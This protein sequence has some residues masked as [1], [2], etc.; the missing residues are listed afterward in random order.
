MKTILIAVLAGLAVALAGVLGY[1]KLTQSEL[2]SALPKTSPIVVSQ[3]VVNQLVV[4]QP[5][6][7]QSAI[8]TS[9]E[10]TEWKTYRNEQY[11]FEMQ[12]PNDWTKKTA[13]DVPYGYVTFAK[14]DPSQEKR[15]GFEDEETEPAYV[16][17]VSVFHNLKGVSL[18]D[19][20]LQGGGG[21]ISEKD[22]TYTEIAGQ[23]A[24]KIEARIAG[25][26][27]SGPNA[28]I[29]VAYKE[30]FYT[31][32]YSG[33]AHSETHYKF[34]DIYNQMLSTFKFTK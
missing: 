11:G 18:R 16:I 6:G 23:Q 22:F 7:N 15:V 12:Y 4:K 9:D 24:I 21:F 27:Q 1:Q 31:L 19:Y 13:Y 25:G 26:T 29:I 3:P 20:V 34:I 30:K 14:Y 32:N 10:T 5:E 17:S 2:I 8:T 33:F 28:T